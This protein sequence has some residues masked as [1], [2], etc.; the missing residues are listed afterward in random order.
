MDIFIISLIIISTFFHAFWNL[1]VKGAQDESVFFEEMLLAVL[2]IGLPFI[3]IDIDFEL[4]IWK[5]VFLS[6]S[7][8]GI[9]YFF[10]SRAYKSGD[11]TTVYPIARSLPVLLLAF[12][13]FLRDRVPGIWGWFGIILVT[14]GCFFA[15]LNSLKQ[16][17]RKNYVNSTTL[18][19]VFG[20]F[21]IVGYTT[22]DKLASELILKGP[23]TAGKYG[24]MFFIFSAVSYNLLNRIL[25]QKKLHL[26]N[27]QKVYIPVLAALFNFVAYWLILWVYQL[28]LR[29]SYV[30][31]FRQFSIILGVAGAFIFL[32]EKFM[33]V[34][35]VGA[36][37]ITAGLILIGLYG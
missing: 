32:K 26:K 2:V 5:Y 30:M 21:A 9:Y 31:A 7:F 25:P 35:A 14:M 18:L 17:R 1:M 24:Y 8:C 13:D 29:V 6:G 36:V 23:F 3:F 19:I 15:P 16:V 27:P 33:P 22:F 28:T 4:R 34:R 20:A 37:L 12:I 11:F 10:L